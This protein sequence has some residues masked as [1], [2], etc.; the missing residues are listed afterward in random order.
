MARSWTASTSTPWRPATT[1]PIA[2]PGRRNSCE[3]LA[4]SPGDPSRPRARGQSA[5]GGG[6]VP[7]RDRVRLPLNL[8]ATDQYPASDPPSSWQVR[9]SGK[10]VKALMGAYG[11]YAGDH[12]ELSDFGGDDAFAGRHR[13]GDLHQVHLAEGHRPP[14]R[15][16]FP[17]RLRAGPGERGRFRRKWATLLSRARR[18][19][20]NTRANSTTSASTS[21]K[22]TPSRGR[23]RT[24]RLSCR[25]LGR[26]TG[27]AGSVAAAAC[28]TRS[29]AATWARWTPREHAPARLR[30]LPCCCGR[31]R[32]RP[33]MSAAKPARRAWVAYALVTVA[34]W[35]VWGAL[36]ALSAQHGFPDTLVYCVGR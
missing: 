26:A 12:V 23:R 36:S 5:G 35:G 10:S 9:H 3:K 27:F 20:A 8:P 32:R 1:R 21:P 11:S 13:R 15:M 30:S 19:A 17:P 4:D 24:L 28:A 7:L 6:T 16:R 18:R 33:R 14:D 29:P 34:L 22:R 25:T 2:T 31:R